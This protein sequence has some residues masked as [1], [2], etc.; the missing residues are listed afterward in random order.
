MVFDYSLVT[1]KNIINSIIPNAPKLKL[2]YLAFLDELCDPID[3]S[4]LNGIEKLIIETN[5]S[6]IDQIDF[7]KCESFNELVLNFEDNEYDDDGVDFEV[8]KDDLNHLE[9]WKFEHKL[10]SVK[11]V[12]V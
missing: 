9:G 1:I 8:I 12:R 5:I 3:F 10:G 4:N 7:S 2:I 6:N 11:G